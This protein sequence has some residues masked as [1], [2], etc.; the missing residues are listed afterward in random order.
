[1]AKRL[2]PLLLLF[3][4]SSCATLFSK[5][6]YEMEVRSATYTKVKVYDSV[7]TLPAKVKVNRSKEALPMVF[8]SDTISKNHLIK[9]SL[10]SKFLYGN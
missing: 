3:F 8:I 7:F 2:L 1:M 6:T 9:A 10:S 5:K 4:L